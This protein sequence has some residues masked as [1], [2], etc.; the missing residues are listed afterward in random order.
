M[1]RS[2]R[3]LLEESVDIAWKYLQQTGQIEDGEEACRFLT[4]NINTMIRRGTISRLLLS[5]NAIAAYQVYR[6]PEA[7]PLPP[8]RPTLIVLTES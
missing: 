6:G 1:Q 7:K 5:N 4:E 8:K 2:L 3:I